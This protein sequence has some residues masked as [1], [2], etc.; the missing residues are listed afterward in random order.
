LP[1]NP[2]TAQTEGRFAAHTEGRCAAQTEGRFASWDSDQRCIVPADFAEAVILWVRCLTMRAL[3]WYTWSR[4]NGQ[5]MPGLERLHESARRSP[6]SLSGA[7]GKGFPPCD[8][9]SVK[10]RTCPVVKPRSADASASCRRPCGA[11]RTRFCVSWETALESMGRMRGGKEVSLE[12]LQVGTSQV[13]PVLRG[14]YP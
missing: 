8:G 13:G 11:R 3:L 14:R 9:S 2:P 12:S 4:H 5:R 6:S 1:P 10:R 7:T